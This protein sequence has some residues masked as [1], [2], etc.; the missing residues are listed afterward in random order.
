VIVSHDWLLVAVHA[1][2]VDVVTEKVPV[3]AAAD[4]DADVGESE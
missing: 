4:G 1:H 2:P 3:P